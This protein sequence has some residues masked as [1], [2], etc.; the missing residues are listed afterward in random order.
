[1][2]KEKVP[3]VNVSVEMFGCK[4]GCNDECEKIM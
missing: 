1:M 3:R 2:F 4:K